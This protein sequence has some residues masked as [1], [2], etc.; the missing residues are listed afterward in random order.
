MNTYK[1]LR[2]WQVNQDCIKE[3]LL[4][5]E[6]LPNSYPVQHIVKQLFRAISFVGANV[7]EGQ[8]NYE[9]KEFIRYLN[10]AIRS[11]I[12]ADH[13]VSTLRNLDV[14]MDKVEKLATL[15]IEVIKMLKG[16]KH[17]IE[18]KR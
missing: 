1:E 13:W 16:L 8:D 18:N 15:N 2:V 7:A 6:K 14:G 4:L 10:I 17:S 3:S 9:G 11:A 12:E 5:F